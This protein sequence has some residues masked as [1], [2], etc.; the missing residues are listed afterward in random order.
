[1]GIWNWEGGVEGTGKNTKRALFFYAGEWFGKGGQENED[2]Q[3]GDKKT[4]SLHGTTQAREGMEI[5][6]CKKGGGN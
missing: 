3:R 6:V 5:K 4:A 1:M 2:M